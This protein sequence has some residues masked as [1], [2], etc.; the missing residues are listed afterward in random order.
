MTAVLLAPWRVAGVLLHGL[1]GVAMALWVFPRLDAAGRHRRTRWWAATM[2]R[3]LGV[4]LRVQGEFRPGAKL[5]VANHLSWLDIMAIHAVCPEARFVSKADVRHWP[6]A[7]RLVDAAGTLYLE[8]ESKRDALRVVHRM[9]EAL[10]AGDTVAVFPEGTT[11]DGHTLLPFHANLLQAA[12]ATATP[13]QAVA[14]RYAEPGHAVSPSARWV[15]AETLA[16]NVWKLARARGV[17]LHLTVLPAEASAH[18]DRR[19]LAARVREQIASVLP[20]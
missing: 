17:V 12:I 18:A 19:A 5:I 7:N 15:G 14:L 8:R 9:A 11:G 1:R 3:C 10:Q 13:V 4:E 2:L 6:V 20:D 16:A